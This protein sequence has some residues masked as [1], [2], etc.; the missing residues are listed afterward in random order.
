MGTELT[1]RWNKIDD[2]NFAKTTGQLIPLILGLFGA[3]R[4]VYLTAKKLY[5]SLQQFSGLASSPAKP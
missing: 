3:I 5:V 4:V 1:L 2:V